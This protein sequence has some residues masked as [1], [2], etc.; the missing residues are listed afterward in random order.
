MRH[1]DIMIAKN[2][3]AQN[4][5][6]P[7]WRP[8]DR[9]R[10]NARRGLPWTAVEDR[11]LLR[12]VAGA[13]SI[14]YAD[15]TMLVRLSPKEQQ[16]IDTDDLSARRRRLGNADTLDSLDFEMPPGC[17]LAQLGGNAGAA[18]WYYGQYAHLRNKHW[19]SVLAWNLSIGA[20]MSSARG[21]G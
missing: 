20:V 19:P 15:P 17:V 11:A 2:G 13:D 8:S 14:G 21:V 10:T 9:A 12:R 16:V 1:Y 6:R 3:W 7:S 4:K 18:A 5:R